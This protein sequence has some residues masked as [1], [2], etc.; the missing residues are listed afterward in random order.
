MI[1]H[2]PEDEARQIRDSF[3][4]IDLILLAHTQKQMI[5]DSLKTPIVGCG[6]DGEYIVLIKTYMQNLKWR[7][8]IEFEKMDTTLE[9][10]T[11]VLSIISK[12]NRKLK[13]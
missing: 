6:R 1:V 13:E 2:G 10:D 3:S 8:K 12:L 7:F 5:L 4:W 11:S 9:E